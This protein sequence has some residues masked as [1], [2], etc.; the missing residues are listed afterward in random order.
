MTKP[1]DFL[2]RRL[3]LGSATA[4]AAATA[5]GAA[6]AIA[7]QARAAGPQGA[8]DVNGTVSIGDFGATGQSDDDTK[9]L[10]AAFRKQSAG[11]PYVAADGGRWGIGRL[12]IPK[13]RFAFGPVDFGGLSQ[14]GMDLGG[15]APFASTL[16]F[17]VGAKAAF[18]FKTY[19]N[20]HLHDLTIRS[21]PVEPLRGVAIDLDGLGGGGNLTLKRLIIEGFGTAIR[22]KG[23]VVGGVANPGNGDKALVEQCLFGS[24]IGY[25]QTRNNQA[26]GWT[27]MNCASGCGEITFKLSGAGETLIVNHTADVY[28][29]FIALPEGSGNSGSGP[30][31]YFGGRTTVMST[32]LEYHGSG[33]RMLVDA[34]G[35]LLPTDSGGSNCDLVFRE[36]SIASGTSW[37]DPAKHV[38]MQVGNERAGSDA[39]RVKQEG[40]TIEGVVKLGSAQLGPVNR[41]WSFRDA[42]RAPD[43]ATVQ[44]LGPGNHC[45]LEWRANENVPLDQYRG[46]QAFI[47][48][49]D[50]QK[51]FLWRHVSRA[52]INTGVAATDYAGRRGGQFTL[53]KFPTTMTVTGLSVFIDANR[54]GADT[55]VEW[56]EDDRFSRVIGSATIAGERRGLCPVVMND[57]SRWKTLSSG[58]VYVRITKPGS[59]D[60]GTEGA[61]VLFYFPY[62]GGISGR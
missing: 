29:S 15:E 40:G 44:F 48:A 14:L 2:S 16:V 10:L 42:V 28:G 25:D 61:L 24:A 23:E 7:D 5:T 49:I 22:N 57:P 38:I 30:R 37:P 41:R 47:G 13:G 9:A 53:G 8:A 33:D 58:E 27:F 43:P 20:L 11:Q 62:M 45:L 46:G 35:S 56:F 55:L 54:T 3:F 19:F 60:D 6:L 50:A 32:K 52:L 51:A 18:S 12:R 17:D 59:N 34:R 36:T 31:N 26:I 39:I 21:A 4:G 1:N